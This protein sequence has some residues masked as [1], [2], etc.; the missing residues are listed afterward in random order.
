MK[1]SLV[2]FLSLICLI[3]SG[4]VILT[5]CT[6]STPDPSKST[7]S[8]ED[9]TKI[10]NGISKDEVISILGNG[11]SS[12]VSHENDTEGLVMQY[13]YNDTEYF[14]IYLD[15]NDASGYVVADTCTSRYFEVKAD[16]NRKDLPSESDID[17]ISSGMRAFEVVDI[18]GAPQKYFSPSSLNPSVMTYNLSNGKTCEILL[19]QNKFLE[20]VVL[21]VQIKD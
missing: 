13:K 1:K 16:E 21:S 4:C 8:K 20:N 3:W 14:L 2:L 10:K 12:S 11:Y 9:T 5:G 19:Q 6:S 18:L 15:G 17:K 7:V